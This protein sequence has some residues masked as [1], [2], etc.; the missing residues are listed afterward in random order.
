[1]LSTAAAS[2]EININQAPWITAALA[3][4]AIKKQ[5]PQQDNEQ[6]Q[7]QDDEQKRPTE[8]TPQQTQKLL[9]CAYQQGVLDKAMM[10][11]YCYWQ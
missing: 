7:Q 9:M 10:S 5:E 2:A 11:A 6:Q 1:M 3:T 4:A 8:A